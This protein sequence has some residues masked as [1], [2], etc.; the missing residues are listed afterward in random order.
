MTSTYIRS[1]AKTDDRHG[2]KIITEYML[3]G[4]EPPSPLQGQEKG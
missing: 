2:D 1:E 3:R 4:L